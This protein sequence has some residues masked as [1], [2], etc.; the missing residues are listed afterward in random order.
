MAYFKR[1]KEKWKIES[2][3]D[4]V[5][6]FIVFAITGSSV[7]F[8]RKPLFSLLGISLDTVHWFIYGLLYLILILPIYQVLLIFWG[9]LFGQFKFFWS[10]EK[11]MLK[12]MGFRFKD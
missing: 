4:L 1:L 9:T 3:K 2:D 7:V 5:I 10:F 6:I 8:V 12:R 11:K